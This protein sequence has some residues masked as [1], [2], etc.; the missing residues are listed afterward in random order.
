MPCPGARTRFD[1]VG[2]DG[3]GEPDKTA[4]TRTITN[5]ELA[6][7]YKNCEQTDYKNTRADARRGEGGE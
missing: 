1:R 2:G 5:N 7:F 4:G 3:S 6:G